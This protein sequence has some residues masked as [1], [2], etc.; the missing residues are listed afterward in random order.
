ML[1]YCI[2]LLMLILNLYLYPLFL[3][4]GAYLKC[5]LLTVYGSVR[6]DEFLYVFNIHLFA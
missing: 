3:F 4:C 5:C 2:I 1:V 6:Y